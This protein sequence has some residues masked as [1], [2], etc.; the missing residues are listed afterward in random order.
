MILGVI[1]FF[2][3]LIYILYFIF[4]FFIKILRNNTK[5]FEKWNF[6]ECHTHSNINTYL[7]SKPHIEDIIKS[8]DLNLIYDIN[9]CL[10]NKN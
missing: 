1:Y 4:Y 5:N 8:L 9:L 7:E 3:F 2:Y 6:G 10:N